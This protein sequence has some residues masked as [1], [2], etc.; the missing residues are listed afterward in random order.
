MRYLINISDGKIRRTDGIEKIGASPTAIAM[1]A[2]PLVTT[3]GA[4]A[5]LNEQLITIQYI[6]AALI[7]IGGYM[8]A[9]NRK[10]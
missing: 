3:V 6:G 9:K 10:K 4:F 7:L 1:L 8:L 2:S 5:L